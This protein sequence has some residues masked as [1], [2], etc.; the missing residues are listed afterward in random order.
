MQLT[1]KGRRMTMGE[2][3]A[4]WGPMAKWDSMAMGDKMA[5]D[6]PPFEGNVEVDRQAGA[7]VGSGII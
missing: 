4:R 3:T 6:E 2:A 5:R 1:D 7:E